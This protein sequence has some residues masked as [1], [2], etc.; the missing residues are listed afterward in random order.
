MTDIDQ[1]AVEAARVAFRIAA[2]Y[3]HPEPIVLHTAD[4]EDVQAAV[5][6]ALVAEANTGAYVP[7]RR[8]DLSAEHSIHGTQVDL[9]PEVGLSNEDGLTTAVVTVDSQRPIDKRALPSIISEIGRQI[10]DIAE[11]ADARVS[12]TIYILESQKG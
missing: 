2:R 10:D 7:R 12:E 8:V 1:H 5:T 11:E 9:P 6:A 3:E 4:F